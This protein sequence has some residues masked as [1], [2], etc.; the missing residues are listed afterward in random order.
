MTDPT[1]EPDYRGLMLWVY[2]SG[3]RAAYNA[4]PTNS[5]GIA[6]SVDRVVL[7]D[8]DAPKIFSPALDMPAVKIVRRNLWGRPAWYVVPLDFEPGEGMDGGTYVGS[9]DSRWYD[10][11]SAVGYPSPSGSVLLPVHDRIEL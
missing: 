10:L 4:W 5:R 9:S 2:R 3:D 1:P 8:E 7:I 11:C 6:P